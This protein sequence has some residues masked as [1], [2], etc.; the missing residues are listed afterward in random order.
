MYP[1]IEIDL[2]KLKQN[3]E[4]FKNHALKNNISE[5]IPVVKVACGDEKI[6]KLFCDSNF[7]YIADSRIENIKKIKKH[8]VKSVLLRL[9]MLSEITDVIKYVDMSLNS[10]L[11]TVFSL[12]IEAKRQNKKHEI[13]FMYD[14]GDLREGHYYKND[15]LNDIKSILSLENIV[16]KGIGTNLTCYGGI[17]P[18]KEILDRLVK[19]KDNIENHFKINLEIIS[20][21]NS[22]SVYL[23]DKALI[24]EEINSLRIGE[25]IFFGKET[26]FS[27]NLNDYHHDIYRLKA[28]I[29][30]VK[31]KPSFPDGMVSIN[32]FGEKVNIADKGMMNRAILAI[33][34]QDVMIE[35]IFPI[36]KRITIVGGSSDHLIVDIG[37]TDYK[38]GDVIDFHVNYPGLLHLM[39]SPYIK[40]IYK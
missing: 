21:G 20:G 34:K 12:N 19:I 2:E 27:S 5:I 31:S 14:L 16:L 40:K 8:K 1:S 13:I 30:E 9:P 32:S 10:E 11:E 23:F 29:I 36:D 17:V 26:A 38:L 33:G 37:E 15:N 6:I 25:T 28:E 3:I 7:S 22:S 39:N 4:I 18:S 24:P 35:N